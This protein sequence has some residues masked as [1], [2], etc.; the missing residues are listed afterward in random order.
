MKYKVSKERGREREVFCRKCMRKEECMRKEGRE[1]V[2][3]RVCARTPPPCVMFDSSDAEG[4][5]LI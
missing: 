4:T 2:R 1:R 3:V 5:P